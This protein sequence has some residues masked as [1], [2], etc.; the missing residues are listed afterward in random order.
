MRWERNRRKLAMHTE[1][2]KKQKKTSTTDAGSRRTKAYK[3]E[4]NRVYRGFITLRPEIHYKGPRFVMPHV[5]RICSSDFEGSAK[6]LLKGRGCTHCRTRAEHLQDLADHVDLLRKAHGAKFKLSVYPVAFTGKRKVLY[7]CGTCTTQVLA[8]PADIENPAFACPE[9]SRRASRGRN[10]SAYV[11]R[12]ALM[13]DNVTCPERYHKSRPLYHEC[14]INGHVHAW[15][16]SINSVLRG[17][18]CPHCKA[19]SPVKTIRPISYRKRTFYLGSNLELKAL[20]IAFNEARSVR[21]LKTKFDHPI[22]AL[23]G[24]HVP[25]YYVKDA[26]LILDVLPAAK[27]AKYRTLVARS[28][29]RAS[30]L[31]Y[32]YGV[33]LIAGDMAIMLKT[34]DWLLE[35]SKRLPDNWGSYDYDIGSENRRMKI[36]TQ[37]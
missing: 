10:T 21:N 25:A 35:R 14:I 7:R 18:G 30:I 28:H 1:V 11:S 19:T 23:V 12:I 26:N 4:L 2:K 8:R 20:A 6:T 15:F 16:A 27:F 31:G 3:T 36:F 17:E 24:K 22:P 32:R 13:F 37:E 33:I 34:T 5:C 9:C 29:S